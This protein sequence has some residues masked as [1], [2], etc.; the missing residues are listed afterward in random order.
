MGA[1]SRLDLLQKWRKW[2]M[3][4]LSEWHVFNPADQKYLSQSS[5]DLTQVSETLSGAN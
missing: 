4:H 2:R 3:N 5:L 1:G